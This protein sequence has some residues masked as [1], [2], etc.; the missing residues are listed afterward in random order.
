MW[1]FLV[2]F[3]SYRLVFGAVQL[4]VSENSLLSEKAGREGFQQGKAYR[5]LQSILENIFLQ[6][7]A[8]FF[9][10]GAEG[11]ETYEKRKQELERK[12]KARKRREKLVSTKRKKL[13]EDLDGFFEVTENGLPQTEISSLWKKVERRMETAAKVEDPDKAANMFVESRA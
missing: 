10:K 4:T 6:L 8:D 12:D 9:R 11:A 3:F 5:Q 7:S 13:A 2:Y 1:L